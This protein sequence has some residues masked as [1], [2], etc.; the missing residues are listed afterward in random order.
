M[1]SMTHYHNQTAI[2]LSTAGIISLS[3]IMRIFYK[4]NQHIALS[5]CFEIF[6]Q[7]SRKRLQSFLY[8]I[9]TGKI[10]PKGAI[11]SVHIWI[12]QKNQENIDLDLKYRIFVPGRIRKIFL[13]WYHELLNHSGASIMYSI[14]RQYLTLAFMKVDV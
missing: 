13:A 12:Y 3:P 6:I 1:K 4:R 14:V 5:A 8:K 7:I 11:G 10:I 2:M 9:I